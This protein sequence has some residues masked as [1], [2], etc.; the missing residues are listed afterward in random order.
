MKLVFLQS[1]P[2]TSLLG[3][4]WG[5]MRAGPGVGHT[6][7]FLLS[8]SAVVAFVFSSMLLSVVLHSIW[9]CFRKG[10]K[11]EIRPLLGPRKKKKKLKNKSTATR[12]SQI[13]I[14]L[15]FFL[16]FFSFLC[17]FCPRT[18]S[19]VSRTLSDVSCTL[20]LLFGRFFFVCV[21]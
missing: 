7:F 20:F 14:F 10:Q 19:C 17:F 15:I 3:Q 11:M 1:T 2:E 6:R 13:N 18:L 9:F 5:S 16:P 8:Y 21:H 12:K 4:S